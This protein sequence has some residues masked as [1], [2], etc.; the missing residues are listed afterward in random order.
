MLRRSARRTGSPLDLCHP[1]ADRRC[2]LLCHDRPDARLVRLGAVAGIGGL[3]HISDGHLDLRCIKYQQRH[4]GS[5]DV[6]RSNE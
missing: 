4:S 2:S 3:H 5:L 6:G 1:P